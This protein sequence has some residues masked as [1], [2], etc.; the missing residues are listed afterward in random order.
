MIKFRKRVD[1]LKKLQLLL[2]RKVYPFFHR[3][4]PLFRQKDYFLK[5]FKEKALAYNIDALNFEEGVVLG[6]F[7]GKDYL[8]NCQPG[9]LIETTIYL[10]KIWEEHLAK[11]MSLYLDGSNG[12]MIDVGANIGANTLPLAAK[13]P[14]IKFHCYEPHPEIFGRLKNNIKLNNFKNIEPVNSA[15]SNST[16]KSLKFYAQ[17]SADNMGRSSLQLN[18]DIKEHDEISVSTISIDDIFANSSDPILL[19]KIDTQGTELEVLQSAKKT[20][21]KFRPTILFELEDRYFLDSER[22]S[23]KKMLKEF[24]EGLDY[25][26][27]NN[28]IGLDYYPQ[29]DITKNYHGDILAVPR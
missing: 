7:Q 11:I 19:I 3:T 2:Q 20:I 29:V 17:K 21:E 9:N 22:D 16:E 25:S 8:M 5:L 15:V 6:S 28:T 14:Q 23:A 10:D 1:K 18:S 27:L 13:H 26:L 4:H 12:A 24:F